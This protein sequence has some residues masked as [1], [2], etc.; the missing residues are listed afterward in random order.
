MT[1]Q[2]NSLEPKP[3]EGQGIAT[4][5]QAAVVAEVKPPEQSASQENPDVWQKRLSD[6]QRALHEKAAKV[7]ELERELE[8]A[9]VSQPA[10]PQGNV[11]P[12]AHP[13]QWGEAERQR[14]VTEY[15]MEPE[16]AMGV[17]KLLQ[18]ANLPTLEILSETKLESMKSNLRQSDKFFTPEVESRFN[19]LIMSRHPQDRM[20]PQIVNECLKTAKGD[21]IENIVE[22]MVQSRIKEFQGNPVNPP[23]VN[24]PSGV[25][26]APAQY[27]LSEAEMQRVS[28]MS[29]K[30][31]DDV[32]TMYKING[33]GK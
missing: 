4:E 12:N 20:I 30:S 28:S 22:S 18:T 1:E 16:Q 9:K 6:T 17:F 33:G 5:P 19:S 24:K 14:Y 10:Q 8:S 2:G 23:S 21:N 13:S 15:G 29:G 27:E 31:M 3:L 25:S 26:S 7:K 11:Y 32:R